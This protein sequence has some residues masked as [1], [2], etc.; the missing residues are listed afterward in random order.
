MQKKNTFRYNNL[1]IE[2]ETIDGDPWVKLK[3]V[4]NALNISDFG[5]AHTV[6][7]IILSKNDVH[8]SEDNEIFVSVPGVFKIAYEKPCRESIEFLRWFKQTV[9]MPLPENA[10]TTLSEA[11]RKL[12]D[13]INLL[14][15][16]RE[17]EKRSRGQLFI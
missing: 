14:L 6:A 5:D 11:I 10:L 2:T 8:L 15:K 16:A 9:L 17:E 7:E 12:T 13:A 3:D 1:Q 4:I